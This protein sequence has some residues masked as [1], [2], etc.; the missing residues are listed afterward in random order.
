MCAYMQVC[1][2]AQEPLRQLQ[3]ALSLAHP[4]NTPGTP[5]STAASPPHECSLV[6]STLEALRPP[7]YLSSSSSTSPHPHDDEHMYVGKFDL[8]I[9]ENANE[10]P[11]GGLLLTLPYLQ[12]VG[13]DDG[14]IEARRFKKRG[15]G[16]VARRG[17]GGVETPRPKLVL[18][19]DDMQL[20]PGVF[21]TL[22]AARRVLVSTPFEEMLLRDTLADGEPRGAGGRA[23][24]GG[25][26]GAEHFASW[27]RGREEEEG[28]TW[29]K[30]G[31]SGSG[32]KGQR[33]YRRGSFSS[34]SKGQVAGADRSMQVSF[35][36]TV[37]LF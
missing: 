19:G 18:V 16:G 7:I 32:T 35:D 21:T 1:T 6:F 31:A 27:Y 8:V 9:V 11:T 33:V 25:A 36:T 10:V 14:S 29:L 24:G 37:G 22:E 20:L 15:V 17:G 5:G 13:N 3:A 34:C 23:R 12:D 2:I 30:R 28:E 26:W 4:L